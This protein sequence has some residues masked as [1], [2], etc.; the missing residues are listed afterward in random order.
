[1]EYIVFCTGMRSTREIC[2]FRQAMKRG[3]WK[4]NPIEINLFSYFLFEVNEAGNQKYKISQCQSQEITL[5]KYVGSFL[6][7]FYF[8][9]N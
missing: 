4:L 3:C 2:L 6:H 5:S 7:S 8:Y 9:D 1:M